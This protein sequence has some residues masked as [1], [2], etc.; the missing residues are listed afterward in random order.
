VEAKSNQQS[1]GN[2]KA[3]MRTA[4][5]CH[6]S[7]ADNSNA[8]IVTAMQ[9]VMVMQQWQRGN[10]NGNG[11]GLRQVVVAVAAANENN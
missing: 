7:P 5:V 3:A 2:I 9:Q 4:E 10:S 11:C 8:S 6:W 1:K